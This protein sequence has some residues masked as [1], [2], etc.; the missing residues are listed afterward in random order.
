[1]VTS[2]TRGGASTGSKR[3]SWIGKDSDEHIAAL[4]AAQSYGS[5]PEMTVPR[6]GSEI[7]GLFSYLLCQELERSGGRGT[8]EE[9]NERVIAAYQAYPCE[10][11]VPGAEGD[12]QRDIRSGATTS[13]PALVCSLRDGVPWLGLGRPAGIEPGA[14]ARVFA[15]ENGQEHGL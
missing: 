9:L 8:Y 11:T 2:A 3:D 14:V 6:G 13:T 4:Y 15:L 12:L 1:G 5:A 10:I 7:H